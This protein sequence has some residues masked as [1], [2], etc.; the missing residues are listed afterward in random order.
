MTPKNPQIKRRMILAGMDT[1]KWEQKLKKG[2]R[3]QT[4]SLKNKLYHIGKTNRQNTIQT[5]G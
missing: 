1:K 2:K 4:V 3:Y 5:V